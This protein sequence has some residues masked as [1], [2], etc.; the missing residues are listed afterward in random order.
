MSKKMKSIVKWMPLLTLVVAVALMCPGH[1]TAIPVG[2]TLSTVTGDVQVMM[3]GSSWQP[4]SANMLLPSGTMVKTGAKSS[5][6]I[7]WSAENVMK[8]TPFTNFTIKDIDID[9]R[10]KTVSSNMDLFV[11]KVKAKAEKLRNPNSEFTITTPTAVAGVRGTV[12][13]LENTADNTT[14]ITTHEGAVDVSAKGQTVSVP[15]G[16]QASVAPGAPPSDPK[17]ISEDKKNSCEMDEDCWSGKCENGKCVGEQKSVEGGACVAGGAI[18]EKNQDCC[19]GSCLEGLCATEAKEDQKAEAC[20][21]DNSDCESDKEC[22]SGSCGEDKKCL[23]KETTESQA[24][25]TAEKTTES[26]EDGDDEDGDD[27][28]TTATSTTAATTA[29]T[30]S[31][32]GDATD[33]ET[34]ETASEDGDEEE[35]TEDSTEAEV[36][37]CVDYG[38]DCTLDE[39]CCSGNCDEGKCGLT[40][41]EEEIEI[42]E[43]KEDGVECAL[44][45]ECCGESCVDGVCGV[46]EE[47]IE[48]F[49]S[50]I[51]PGDGD[52]VPIS[53]ETGIVTG[54]T[55]SG[56]MC[57]IGGVSV[58]AGADGKFSAELPIENE[59]ET[60]LT[61]I[62][63][64]EDGTASA[65][66]SVTVNVIGMPLLDISSPADG[67]QNCPYIDIAGITTPGTTVTVNG[68]N[69]MAAANV[70]A[71]EGAFQLN[72][73]KLD[74]CTKP[75]E[76]EAVDEY[77]QTTRVTINSGISSNA[78]L[79]GIQIED[80][81]LILAPSGQW[82][83]GVTS[84]VANVTVKSSTPFSSSLAVEFSNSQGEIIGYRNIVPIGGLTTAALQA[85]SGDVAAARTA[86]V[87]VAAAYYAQ[88]EMVI[89]TGPANPLTVIAKVGDFQ[90]VSYSIVL[91][92]IVCELTPMQPGDGI[93]NDCDGLVDEDSVDGFDNDGDGA[94]DEDQPMLGMV[95][96]DG[97]DNDGDGLIDEE[98]PD[99]FDADGDGAID[100]GEIDERDNDGDGIAGEDMKCAC[101][102]ND[103]FA[104]CDL[105][106]LV[107]GE[108][109]NANKWSSAPV[110]KDSPDC[111]VRCNAQETPD[112]DCDKDGLLNAQELALGTDPYKKDTDEDG[113][114]D[115]QEVTDGTDPFDPADNAGSVQFEQV[116]VASDI[117]IGGQIATGEG[118]C[119]CPAGTKWDADQQSCVVE[120]FT[121]CADGMYFDY[122]IGACVSQCT[123][124][125]VPDDSIGECYCQEGVLSQDGY[126]VADCPVEMGLVADLTTGECVCG[127]E[128]P[129]FDE[130][131]AMCVA[132]CSGGQSGDTSIGLCVCPIGTYKDFAARECIQS[133]S[134]TI[135]SSGTA[136]AGCDY[137]MYNMDCDGDGVINGEDATP[138][139]N[140]GGVVIDNDGTAQQLCPADSDAPDCNILVDGGDCDGDG[141]ANQNDPCPC[142]WGTMESDFCPAGPVGCSEGKYLDEFYGACLEQCISPKVP[143]TE[144]MTC[145]C[146]VG[147]YMDWNS[148]QCVSECPEGFVMGSEG[149]CVCPPE[150]PLWDDIAQSCVAAC[151][152][153]QIANSMEPICQCPIDSGPDYGTGQCVCF[154]GSLPDPATNQCL[155]ERDECAE[156]PYGQGCG[157][158]YS[159]QCGEGLF[160]DA[161]AG[162]CAP[163]IGECQQDGVCNP[164]YENY[165][166]CP[167][168]CSHGDG[169]CDYY[170]AINL[171]A[172]ADCSDPAAGETSCPNGCI[173]TNAGF[174]CDGDGYLNEM[175]TCPCDPEPNSSN[176]CPCWAASDEAT[177]S[178]EPDCE[179]DGQYCDYRYTEP[180]CY[181]YT[182]NASCVSDPSCYWNSTYCEM[183]MPGEGCWQYSTQEACD[184]DVACDWDGT[185]C[186]DSTSIPDCS[187]YTDPSDCELSALCVWSGTECV[188]D[189]EQFCSFYTDDISCE[190]DPGCDWDGVECIAAVEGNCSDIPD[191]ATCDSYPACMWDGMG[192]VIDMGVI[193]SMFGSQAEC[194]SEAACYWDGSF[195]SF[196]QVT[197]C[198]GYYEQATCESDSECYWDGFKCAY[199]NPPDCSVY[200]DSVSCETEPACYWNGTL[201]ELDMG[202]DCSVYVDQATCETDDACYWDGIYCVEDMPPV[203]CSVYADQATCDVNPDCY[204]DGGMMACL[205]NGGPDC[206]GYT[207]QASCDADMGCY[208]DGGMMACMYNTGSA[209][210]GY[211][212]QVSCENDYACIWDGTM[213]VGSIASVCGNYMDQAACETDPVCYWDGT[214]CV[215]GSGVDCAMYDSDQV[216]CDE[217]LGCH[218]DGAYCVSDMVVD[219]STYYDQATCVSDPACMWDGVSCVMSTPAVKVITIRLRVKQR[220]VVTGQVHIAKIQCRIARHIMIRQHVMQRR[221]VTGMEQVV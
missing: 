164:E 171:N 201:C 203:D 40:L 206:S 119:I 10:T 147:T 163:I 193:C 34:S 135:C 115:I 194:D 92:G 22:C 73:Y 14:N 129:Y 149:Y 38:S 90:P 183:Y 24:E 150:A 27:E 211:Y 144:T 116:E 55:V 89:F 209:C 65:E 220:W 18:C 180:E 41:D 113:Y 2:A 83:D 95:C 71:N 185:Q 134:E 86:A 21:P 15:A 101:D 74:D 68:F 136:G 23:K 162:V 9:P 59:G 84:V 76:F 44:D 195:C 181:M 122:A 124:G 178:A 182:D 177:C 114:S 197:G 39:E 139:I 176:G 17:P 192:C 111:A 218:W 16:Q 138:C 67:F 96:N 127:P 207:D 170:E 7:K 99:G 169:V 205:Y 43:C 102:G 46:K 49:V 58:T 130:F 70:E 174:D 6:V 69:I 28:T 45:E 152:G 219:C 53:Q 62:C 212:D 33:E 12:F 168:D 107:N 56:A 19:N 97:I 184:Y 110:T 216:M 36:A 11:G 158:E 72:H 51:Q 78:E 190:S 137:M 104:D 198:M 82:V 215:G 133:V 148:G 64:S 103:P 157:C 60:S 1:V 128:T 186:V 77:D 141:A 142:R 93:D 210:D 214:Y 155:T 5:A 57:S 81:N 63:M 145:V 153:G 42:V 123:G 143:D 175:D 112:G 187:T 4:G 26:D 120:D 61:V 131:S 85:D 126:C 188:A 79:L 80:V 118:T 32:A 161:A 156:T 191:Q 217:T 204:W 146:P 165:L 106:G 172:P 213:C 159:S 221:V 125:Q 100:S 87:E 98:S 47:P 208:W 151:T 35:G 52:E 132:A 13:D 189:M 166:T 108:D 20:I 154:D 105:D 167:S 48:M 94:I 31:E 117:C 88:A 37:A 3:P 199:V 202:P 54:E 160:C 179:W 91:R 66:E 29:T 109:C 30:S 200:V 173:F 75:L 121:N 196:G 8:L 25:K 140:E 50:I